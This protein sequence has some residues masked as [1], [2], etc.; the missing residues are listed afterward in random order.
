M[1]L[2]AVVFKY[3]GRVKSLPLLGLGSLKFDTCMCMCVPE[4][5]LVSHMYAGAEASRIGYPQEELQRVV[6]HHVCAGTQ[7]GSSAGALGA[8][9][10]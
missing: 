3:P 10:S 6:S 1:F 4:C 8:L 2:R 5:M 7:S 9:S